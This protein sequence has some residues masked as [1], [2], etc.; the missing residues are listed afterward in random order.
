MKNRDRDVDKRGEEQK[1]SESP[2]SSKRRFFDQ[3]RTLAGTVL[4]RQASRKTPSNPPDTESDLE[5]PEI[6]GRVPLKIFQIHVMSLA[7]EYLQTNR[8]ELHA[9]AL[10]LMDKA[11]MTARKVYNQ[12]HRSGEPRFSESSE[13]RVNRHFVDWIM[14]NVEFTEEDAIGELGSGYG[15]DALWLGRHTKAREII[16][17]DESEE[18]V[19]AA[20]QQAKEYGLTERVKFIRGNFLQELSEMR[21]RG[22]QT[23]ISHST[24]HYQPGLV[25]KKVTF[26]LLAHVLRQAGGEKGGRLCLAMKTVDSDSAKAEKHIR[27]AHD[28]YFPSIEKKRGVFRVYPTE[29]AIRDMLEPSFD[30][31]HLKVME[32]PDYDVEGETEV[33]VCIIATPKKVPEAVEEAA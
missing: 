25:L 23:L 28:P 18:A 3:V 6:K 12:I 32:V 26:P 10:D 19:W 20:Q 27:L 24:L 4:A 15:N 14:E 1:T 5:L 13:T 9:K 29:Q 30:I 22:C 33:F 17:A 2:K 21:D 7:R 31:Q 8:L 11:R 16:G